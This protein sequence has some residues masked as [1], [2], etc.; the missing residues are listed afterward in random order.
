MANSLAWVRNGVSTW[1]ISV[2]C[3]VPIVVVTVTSGSTGDDRAGVLRDPA[4]AD[5]AAERQVAQTGIRVEVEAVEH[6]ALAAEVV[7]GSH[8]GV[9]LAE[10]VRI[11]VAEA[12]ERP[13]LLGSRGSTGTG[14]L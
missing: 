5:A 13:P 11:D 4:G 1:H 14:M 6:F 9:H 12:A 7:G 3:T 2:L 8:V 10:L